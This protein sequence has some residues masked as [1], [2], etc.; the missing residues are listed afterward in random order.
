MITRLISSSQQIGPRMFRPSG[1]VNADKFAL[2]SI[3]FRPS[4]HRAARKNAPLTPH[5]DH[6]KFLS[7]PKPNQTET[8]H[9][10]ESDILKAIGLGALRPV[11][12]SNLP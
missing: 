6:A 2:K 11:D 9:E 8:I 7:I 12:V 5:E 1:S 4:P 3:I 10:P